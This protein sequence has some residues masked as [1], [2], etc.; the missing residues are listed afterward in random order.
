MTMRDRWLNEGMAVLAEQGAGGVRVDRI[1][2]RLG[3][4]KGSFHHHFDGIA[5]YHRALWAR[6]ESDSI[7]AIGRAVTAVADLPPERA[8]MDLPAHVAFDP[9]IEAAIRGWA[10]ENDDAR[11]VQRRVDAARLDALIS[12][13]QQILPDPG[14]AR[15]AALVPHLL[16]I[17]ASVALPRPTTTDLH[18]VFALLATLVPA[19]H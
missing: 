16:M 4:T 7:D 10:F 12:L 19:V 17:G 2:A 15:I 8:V 1:A 6:Y 5:D 9:R 3:L 14:R 18:E 11:A 13:W